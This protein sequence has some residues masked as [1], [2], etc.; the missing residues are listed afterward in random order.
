MAPVSK[1]ETSLSADQIKLL[2]VVMSRHQPVIKP[3]EWEDIAAA[4]GAS[5]GKA[6]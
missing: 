2:Q 3:N 6:A 5:N 1:P 4:I